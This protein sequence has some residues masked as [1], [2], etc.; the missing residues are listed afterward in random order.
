MEVKEITDS[1]SVIERHRGELHAHCM[2]MLRSREDA[3][4]ALQDTL[5]RAWR[6]LHQY[7]GRGSVRSWLYRIATNASLDQMRRRDQHVIHSDDTTA[8]GL[9]DQLERREWLRRLIGAAERLPERQRTVFAHREIVGLS[10]RETAEALGTTQA[11]VN[12]AMQRARSSLKAELG[13]VD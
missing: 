8:P 11:S 2:R 9:D 5:L 3:E 7:E 4:D 10:A 1:E 12:S 6:S 13:A